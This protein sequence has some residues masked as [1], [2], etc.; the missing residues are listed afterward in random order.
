ML[1]RTW[2]WLM[3]ALGFVSLGVGFV[4][5]FLPLLP[6][7][8]LVLLAAFF[9]S[10]GSKR[11]HDWLRGHPRFGPY[12]CDW[13]AEQVI[14]PVAKLASTALMVPSVGYVILTR[15]LPVVLSAGMALTVAAVLWFIWSRPARRGQVLVAPESE[16]G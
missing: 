2:R 6:T 15:D 14:P 8:P 9:F 4:G 16:G 5:I 12:V 1:T 7:T 13:E 3:I 11:L 10:K